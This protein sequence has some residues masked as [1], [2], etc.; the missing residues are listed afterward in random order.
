MLRI[1]M[2]FDNNSSNLKFLYKIL[3]IQIQILQKKF[4]AFSEGVLI[5]E[6]FPVSGHIGEITVIPTTIDSDPIDFWDMYEECD[7]PVRNINYNMTMRVKL[8]LIKSMYL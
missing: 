5:V 6:N 8:F 7:S 4:E 2:R 1:S 3:P